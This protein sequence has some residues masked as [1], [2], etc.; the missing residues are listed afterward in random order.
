MFIDWKS[1]IVCCTDDVSGLFERVLD[2]ARCE[3]SRCS[4]IL[5][6]MSVI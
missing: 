4:C 1:Q 2:L 6:P 3:E 5:G